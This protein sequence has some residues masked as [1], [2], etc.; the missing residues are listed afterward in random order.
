MISYFANRHYS[1]LSKVLPPEFNKDQPSI[2]YYKTFINQ[3]TLK[4]LEQNKLVNHKTL[5]NS[6]NKK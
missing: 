2:I 5:R 4:L 3:D 6:V 1:E